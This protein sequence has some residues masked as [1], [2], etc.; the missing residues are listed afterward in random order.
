MS[1]K[2]FNYDFSG[3][4]T[5]NDI[6]CSDG[7]V[8]CKD[9]FVEQDGKQVP[10]VWNHNH[11]D[12]EGVL[13][14]AILE[15]R[16][17]GVY[18]YCSFNNTSQGKNAKE[19]VEH[20]DI[21]S[22][23]IF[24]NKLKQDGSK[25]VHGMIR[26]VS[27]VLA[28]A[29]PG[30]FIENVV[31]HSDDAYEED[32]TSACIYNDD[33]NLELFHSEENDT[34]GG[35]QMSIKND[36]NKEVEE[37]SSNDSSEDENSLK[38]EDNAEE[39]KEGSNSKSEETV[40]DVFNTLSEK[41]KTVV[42]AIMAELL[43]KEGTEEEKNLMKHNAFEN[44]NNDNT[45]ENDHAL[46]HSEFVEIMNNA[47]NKNG[48]V[49]AAFLEHGI[50]DVSNLY[51]EVHN[52]TQTPKVVDIEHDWVSVIINGVKKTPFGRIKSTYANLT[53]QEARAKG[54]VKGS[55]KVEEVILAA[56]RT[57]EPTTVYKLQKMDRDDVIDI[58][59]FDVLSWIKGE[60]RIKL[61]EEQARA[62]LV[63]DGRSPLSADKIPE[64]HIRPIASDSNVY[65]TVVATYEANTTLAQNANSIVDDCVIG[66]EDY[67]GAGNPVGFVRRDLLSRM[68]LLK[69][70]NGRRIYKDI[71]ELAT[72]MM[73]SKLVPVPASV[74]GDELLMVAVDLS[75][76]TLGQPNKGNTAF[77]DNFDLNVNKYE[78]LIEERCSGALVTP[79]SALV[80]KKALPEPSN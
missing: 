61:E 47:S 3:W 53:G 31:K 65:A 79:Y 64:D 21:C 35:E 30:A 66:M 15:N 9:A 6:R 56:K 26:E 27:L 49:K 48:S 42:Y 19:L 29:N 55:Q 16:D 54:Y 1:K 39:N 11:T 5:K 40:A 10:L 36:E 7:R 51:P 12:G 13:G 18:A 44:Q 80:F 28:G 76:Y 38:H 43:D 33:E 60:M 68:L 46:T 72:A 41:Q 34:K 62:I 77:F 25:V 8:I 78:Y 20:G 52:V 2:S 69:D 24:A 63:G 14:H 75:D 4:A 22:L 23:S 67:K 32:E 59:D 70:V 45:N 58:T 50:T 71:R 57:T 74:F 73:L 37:N 17:Q